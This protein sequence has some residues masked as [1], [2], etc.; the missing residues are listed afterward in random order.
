M[1]KLPTKFTSIG[2]QA[3]IE[4]VM[5][6]SPHFV[7]IAVRKPNGR[8]VIKNDPFS[9]IVQK[10]PFL[11]K[12]V[13]RGV[14]TLIE[15]MVHGMGALSYSAQVASEGEDTGEKLSTG[16][17]LVSMGSAFLM[18]MG[19]FVALPHYLTV[20]MTSESA[21]GIS[22]KSPLF[23][24]LDGAMKMG[25]LLSYVYLIALMKDI[26]RVFQ[27][28][29]AEH[30]SIYT[31][32]SGQDL[33]VENARRFPT[34]H[35]RCGTSFLLFL[36]LISIIVFSI[37]FPVFGLTDLTQT[38][39]LNHVLMIVIKMALMM[40]VAGL[41]YEFIKMCACRMQNPIFRAIIWPGMVLQK[42]TTREPTDDQLEVALASLRQVLKLEKEEF[43][44]LPAAAAAGGGSHG[45]PRLKT[46]RVPQIEIGQLAELGYVHASVAEFPEN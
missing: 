45:T 2:G 16:A 9:S 46:A 17:I 34:L 38:K 22:P 7:A 15:S 20:L 39:W 14:V 12:P 23:H 25:I 27:Y 33:T 10:Y 43:P 18:G 37:I 36:V 30:K 3:V 13:L 32:E 11:G 42:L 41:A 28:H 19:L 44:D 4:G 21:L 1:M 24:L 26:K 6:R 31:F 5:M 8:I 40:P 35:P 29:G